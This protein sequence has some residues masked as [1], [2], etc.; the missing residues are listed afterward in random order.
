MNHDHPPGEDTPLPDP[1]TDLATVHPFPARPDEQDAEEGELLTD[2]E[3]EALTSQRAQALARWRGYRNDVVTVARTAHAVATHHRTRAAGRAIARHAC[4]IWAGGKVALTRLSDAKTGARYERLMRAAE[5]GGDKESLLEWESRAEAARQARHQRRMDWLDSPAKL[6]KA[7]AVA[8]GTLIGGLLALGIVLAIANRDIGD[9]LG[10]LNALITTIQWVTWAFLIAW[11]PFLLAAPGLTLLILWGIGRTKG[12]TPAWV[13]GPGPD[14]ADGETD[15]M[16]ALPDENTIVNALRNLNIRGFNQALKQGWRLRFIMPPVLDGKGWR[17]QIALPPACPVFEIVKRKPMLAHN[18]M[19]FPIEVWPT[20]P[21]PSVL[22]LWVAQPGALSGPVE[23]WPLLADLDTATCDYFAGIP[24]AVTIRGDVVRGRL[25]EA[26]Y[27]AGGMM[28]SGKSSLV[29]TLLLGAILDPLVDADVVV[30]AENADYEPMRPRLRSLT[31][32]HPDDTVPVAVAKLTALYADLQTR[33]EALKQHDARSV[34][35]SLAEKDARLR[36]RILVIDE[37]QALFMGKQGSTAIEIA[38]KLISASRKYAITLMFLTP[39]P[40][41]DAL[42]RKV[43]S[44]CSNK[45]C[46]AIGDQIGNDAVLGTGSYKAGISAVG[47]EPKTEESNGD[48]GTFMARGFTPKPGLL[49]SFYVSQSDAHRVVARAMQLREQRGITTGPA[50][51]LEA[52]RDFLADLA[53]VMRGEQR[54]R[55]E[56]IRQRLAELHPATYEGWAATDLADAVRDVEIPIVKTGGN[57]KIF[58]EDVVAARARQASAADDD[59][60]DDEDGSADG[61]EDSDEFD[62]E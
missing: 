39:E 2:A 16:D 17:A 7:L 56:V 22:D 27:A 33:G 61:F 30:M 5:A 36:P 45:A 35:R 13:H 44:V 1:G 26:N 48:V 50:P 20:E 8:A 53:T 11:V 51:A 18:L 47:L 21:Q 57:K 38:A 37:C 42:P 12:E 23:P 32:G 60:G 31:T 3:Y 4:Y 9:V 24:V 41:K 52:A 59:S 25:H 15:I 55:T 10:P 40:S 19:R 54:V 49:R 6:A 14:G 29:I 58:A 34:T 62:G 43:G 46:F 28:G